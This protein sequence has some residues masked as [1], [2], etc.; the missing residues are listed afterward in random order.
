MSGTITITVP[1]NSTTVTGGGGTPPQ[2]SGI[3]IVDGVITT[4]ATPSQRSAGRSQAFPG[5]GHRLGGDPPQP[6]QPQTPPPVQTAPAPVL[7]LQSAPPMRVGAGAPPPPPPPPPGSTTTTSPWSGI[8][9]R[10]G[11]EDLMAENL[12]WGMTRS[13]SLAQIHEDRLRRAARPEPESFSDLQAAFGRILRARRSQSQRPLPSLDLRNPC[14]QQT[15]LPQLT[16]HEIRLLEPLLPQPPLPCGYSHGSFD[17]AGI[18][19]QFNSEDPIQVLEVV[20]SLAQKLAS[21][22]LDSIAIEAF[23]ARLSALIDKLCN[24]LQAVTITGHATH[25]EEMLRRALAVFEASARKQQAM[26]NEARRLLRDHDAARKQCNLFKAQ[27]AGGLVHPCLQP[28]AVQAGEVLELLT[29][30]FGHAFLEEYELSLVPL[31]LRVRLLLQIVGRC[32]N[33]NARRLMIHSTCPVSLSVVNLCRNRLRAPG[34]GRTNPTWQGTA[35]VPLHFHS[36]GY[37]ENLIYSWQQSSCLFVHGIVGFHLDN[38]MSGSQRKTAEAMELL[39]ED[40][41]QFAEYLFFGNLLIPVDNLLRMSIG[42]LQE[43]LARL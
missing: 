34:D 13:E 14:N 20:R 4:N 27:L 16:P 29:H 18:L 30:L 35:F 8:G 6:P 24:G 12:E 38:G 31:M 42:E 22:H 19:A 36:Q 9:H 17:S 21:R 7:R 3:Y 28:L 25:N 41:T 15:L 33:P 37:S 26:F 1:T 32:D 39:R 5:T 11:G 23:A 43:F 2:P 10:L 40:E